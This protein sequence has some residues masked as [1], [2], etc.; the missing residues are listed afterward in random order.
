VENNNKNKKK[1]EY[2]KKEVKQL[3]V[4]VGRRGEVQE[5]GGEAQ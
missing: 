1:E 2:K 3:Q 5:R 4:G